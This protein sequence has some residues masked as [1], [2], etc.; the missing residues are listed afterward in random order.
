MGYILSIICSFIIATVSTDRNSRVPENELWP[1]YG[2]IGI[3]A[4]LIVVIIVVLV[5]NQRRKFNE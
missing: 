4:L 1:T 2:Y 3:G 5:R